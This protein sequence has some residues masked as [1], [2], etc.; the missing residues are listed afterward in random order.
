[1]EER[2]H[3]K[4]ACPTLALRRR[5]LPAAARKS[6]LP[7]SRF[8]LRGKAGAGGFP[9]RRQH[10]ARPAKGAGTHRAPAPPTR[11][12][13]PPCA[14][15]ASAV[16]QGLAICETPAGLGTITRPPSANLCR[17]V[18][19]KYLTLPRRPAA[20]GAGRPAAASPAAS[21][22]SWAARLSSGWSRAATR[23]SHDAAS[24]TTEAA[25]AASFT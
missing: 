19:T 7:L 5:E 12:L 18:Y 13:P 11:G 4:P 1:M 6:E 17:G 10:A 8:P 20:A 16:R 15:P 21:S 22:S 24:L 23:C 2:A 9:P 3:S 14:S 25:R